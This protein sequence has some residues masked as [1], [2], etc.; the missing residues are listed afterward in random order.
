MSLSRTFLLSLALTFAGVVLYAASKQSDPTAR[1]TVTGHLLMDSIF[2]TDQV[3]L[4]AVSTLPKDGYRT[5]VDLRP[6]GEATDQPPSSAVGDAARQAGLTFAYIPTPQGEIP[7]Q[8]VADLARALETAPKPVI[9]YCR[10]GKRAARVWALAEASRPGG[11]S[12]EAI[13]SAVRA[14]GQSVDDLAGQIATRIAARKA[15]SP[16]KEPS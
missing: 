10:S 11:A 6:D 13:A 12:A 9:M 3:P 1:D 5:L 2:V 8:V 16:A 7:E 14:A 4:S 15:A